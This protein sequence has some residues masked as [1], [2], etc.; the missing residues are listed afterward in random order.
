MLR[1]RDPSFSAH[2]TC[3]QRPPAAAYRARQSITVGRDTP[4]FAAI[5]VFHSPSAANHTILAR[6]ANPARPEDDRTNRDSTSRSPLTRSFI[7]GCLSLGHQVP[8]ICQFV[9]AVGKLRADQAPLTP[10]RD[11]AHAVGVGLC[12]RPLRKQV[13]QVTSSGPAPLGVQD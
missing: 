12:A 9:A 4:T 3:G 8:K 11:V 6:C 10:A 5:A 7:D 1:S 13:D 2:V